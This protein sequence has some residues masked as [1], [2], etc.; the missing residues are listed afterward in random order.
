[1]DIRKYARNLSKAL[2]FSDGDHAAVQALL[3]EVTS[4][5]EHAAPRSHARMVLADALQEFGRDDEAMAARNLM[6]FQVIN[7]RYVPQAYSRG[8]LRHYENSVLPD[9]LNR[10]TDWHFDYGN[11]PV[12]TPHD[13]RPS[14][15]HDPYDPAHHAYS[16]FHRHGM[17][18]VYDP[19]TVG[20]EE[21]EPDR[22]MH[23]SELPNHM[24]D[25]YLQ[26]L[27]RAVAEVGGTDP[28]DYRAAEDAINDMRLPFVVPHT[29][30]DHTPN[31][32]DRHATSTQEWEHLNQL[33][34]HQY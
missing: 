18:A 23:V 13:S 28:R 1:M 12:H 14:G 30:T 33:P 25:H 5:P 24:A 34:Q 2:K 19:P 29:V 9:I 32:A 7:G 31:L 6:P 10:A 26:E 16:M 15:S 22:V 3:D 21:R 27:H 4:S 17:V 8:P 20:V 11:I